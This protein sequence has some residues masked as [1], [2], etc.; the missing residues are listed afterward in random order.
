ML[1]LNDMNPLQLS[2]GVYNKLKFLAQILLP[3]LGA[4]YFA[5]AGIWGFPH[6]EQVVGTITAVDVFLGL[7]LTVSSKVYDA[8]DAKYDADLIIQ[9]QD[10]GTARA[11]LALR[12]VETPVDVAQQKEIRVK[13]RNE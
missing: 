7:F 2:N 11:N 13:V 4:L 5:L 3:G 8:S 6:A 12:H 10:D 1:E 9:N